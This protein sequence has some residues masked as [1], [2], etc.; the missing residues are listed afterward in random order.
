MLLFK[1][2]VFFFW[3]SSSIDAVEIRGIIHDSLS[4]RVALTQ[5]NAVY[6]G[7]YAFNDTI[8]AEDDFN[9][10]FFRVRQYLL[11]RWKQKSVVVVHKVKDPEGGRHQVRFEGEC[12]SIAQAESHIPLSFSKKCFF[13][14]RGWEYSLG[15]MRVFVEEIEGLPPSVEVIAASKEEIFDLFDDL[16][17]SE[18]LTG[19]VPEWYCKSISR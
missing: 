7:D 14:R 4:A 2:L 12:D 17:V 13:F 9:D 10:E 18:V 6:Q 5:A 11:T 8:Y 15:N 19:S 3:A 1:I 16:N